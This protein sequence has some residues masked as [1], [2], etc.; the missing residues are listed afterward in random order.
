M[1][2]SKLKVD[3]R[4]SASVGLLSTVLTVVGW[5]GLV[6]CLILRLANADEPSGGYYD[7]LMGFM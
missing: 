1:N 6:I 7:T 2:K 5:V 4:V 3:V